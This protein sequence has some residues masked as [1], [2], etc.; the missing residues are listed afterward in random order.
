MHALSHLLSLL[1]DGFVTN[2]VLQTVRH[3]LT[4]L[5]DTVHTIFII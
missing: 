4:R 1:V 2:A 3:Q 5:I